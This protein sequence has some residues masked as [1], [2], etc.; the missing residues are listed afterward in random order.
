MYSKCNAMRE[1]EHVF[2]V[3][4]R[5]DLISWNTLIGGHM[6]NE[7][8]MEAMQTFVWM[9]EAGIRANYITMV[10]FLGICSAPKD[11]M[12]HG[13]PLHAHVVTVG[14]D[15]DDFVKNSLIAMYAKCG[16]FSSSEFIFQKTCGFLERH[17][18]LESSSWAWGGCTEA[19][20]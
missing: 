1:S 10:N 15:S 20:Y 16:D 18:F 9:R 5:R 17:N 8:H 4:T 3:I 13:M 12:K 2:Q 7:E 14:F 11:L 19:L 6:E